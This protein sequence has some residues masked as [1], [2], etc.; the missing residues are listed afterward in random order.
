MSRLIVYCEAT[1][2]GEM[3]YLGYL[4][5]FMA[6]LAALSLFALQ[7]AH[8]VARYREAEDAGSKERVQI[9]PAP[10]KTKPRELGSA[11]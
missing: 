10:I 8:S 4:L 6:A 3:E 9:A 1:N 11:A 5:S 7:V 2:E